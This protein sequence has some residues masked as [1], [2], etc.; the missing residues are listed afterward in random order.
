MNCLGVCIFCSKPCHKEIKSTVP[1]LDT[2]SH[3]IEPKGS[4]EVM[5]LEVVDD[6]ETV[7]RFGKLIGK[8][9]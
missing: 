7:K 3:P 5:A 9:K 6:Y 8:K 2:E 4:N 1:K